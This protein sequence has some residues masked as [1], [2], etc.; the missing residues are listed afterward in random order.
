MECD[1]GAVATN[2]SWLNTITVELSGTLDEIHQPSSDPIDWSNLCLQMSRAKAQYTAAYSTHH[3]NFQSQLLHT[4]QILDA[5][6]QAVPEGEVTLLNEIRLFREEVEASQSSGDRS[7]QQ[8]AMIAL[9]RS[10]IQQLTAR[11]EELK[12]L[13]TATPRPPSP[14]PHPPTDAEPKRHAVNSTDADEIDEHSTFQEVEPYTSSIDTLHDLIRTVDASS[15]LPEQVRNLVDDPISLFR[16]LLQR[17][18]ALCMDTSISI[19]VHQLHPSWVQTTLLTLL[20]LKSSVSTHVSTLTESHRC[21]RF[22][23]KQTQQTPSPAILKFYEA[24][25]ATGESAV[26]DLTDKG[27]VAIDALHAALLQFAAT[28]SRASATATTTLDCLSEA[29]AQAQQ[30]LA[31]QKQDHIALCQSVETMAQ[32]MVQCDKAFTPPPPFNDRPTAIC[33]ELVAEAN[34]TAPEESRTARAPLQLAPPTRHRTL[35]YLGGTTLWA[36]VMI[37]TAVFASSA[38]DAFVPQ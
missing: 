29:L 20:D 26:Q 35:L 19:D 38:S 27:V 9:Q 17:A 31:I 33:T 28:A 32:S 8:Q 25:I 1:T 7:Q 34:S 4:Q 15:K 12:T 2:A 10:K 22:L 21:Q 6:A 30:E 11:I 3:T 5:F 13:V 14:P 36:T 23:V 18:V 16:W 37:G 24:Q